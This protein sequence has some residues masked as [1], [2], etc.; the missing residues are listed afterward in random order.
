MSED[1]KPADNETSQE[2]E[3][4]QLLAS[5]TDPEIPTV[6]IV[7]LGLIEY[8]QVEGNQVE[9]GFVPTFAGCP[10]L[11]VIKIQIAKVLME[12]GFVPRVK[13][14]DIPW[15]TDRIAESAC[16]KMKQIGLSP[17]RKH[18]G[19]FDPHLT[20][21]VACPYCGSTETVMESPFGPTLCRAIYYCRNCQQP[22]EK[23]KEL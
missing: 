7:E 14:L 16:E 1:K 15:T 12:A 2:R 9:V 23:F 18:G 13:V 3:V 20:G 17:P 5:I 4:W 8:V 22:F 11:G 10:A 21:K 6:N 19:S